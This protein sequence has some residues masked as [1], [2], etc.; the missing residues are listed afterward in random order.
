[1][2]LSLVLL[3][4]LLG[5]CSSKGADAPLEQSGATGALSPDGKPHPGRISHTDQVTGRAW[6]DP[7]G[8]GPQSVA[9]A[10]KDGQWVPVVKIILTGSGDRRE[11]TK[12]GPEGEVLERTQMIASPGQQQ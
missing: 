3:I 10:R 6:T 2:R 11:I 1:M 4:I 7:A 12:Y 8:D 5:G 9:W